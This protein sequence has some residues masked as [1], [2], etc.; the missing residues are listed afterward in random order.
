MTDENRGDIPIRLACGFESL[1]PEWLIMDSLRWALGGRARRCL[2]GLRFEIGFHI[3]SAYR[4]VPGWAPSN[5][6]CCTVL[7][8]VILPTF[9]SA[10]AKV[11]TTYPSLISGLG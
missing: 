3:G 9:P 4:A 8:S 6:T 10:F 5:A 2:S 7:L 11:T 1:I